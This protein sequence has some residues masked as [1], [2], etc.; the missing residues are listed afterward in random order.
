MGGLFAVIWLISTVLIFIYGINLIISK[1]KKNDLNKAKNKFKIAL[2]ISIISFIITGVSAPK[3]EKQELAT[4]DKI[5]QE[6]ILSGDE[7]IL[8]QENSVLEEIDTIKEQIVNDNKEKDFSKIREEELAK[9]P[10][11]SNSPY[12]VINSNVPFFYDS[13]LVTKSYEEY[14]ALDNFRKM[15]SNY[16]L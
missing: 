7:N 6:S 9:I 5:I 10:S 16:S 1:V 12:Y 15:Y 3:T 4:G 14:G 13:D 8:S 2:F 11:Y